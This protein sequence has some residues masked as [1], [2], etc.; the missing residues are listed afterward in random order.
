MFRMWFYRYSFPNVLALAG[1]SVFERS[2]LERSWRH[3]TDAVNPPKPRPKP[4]DPKFCRRSPDLGATLICGGTGSTLEKRN[5]FN[6]EAY[7]YYDLLV[8]SAVKV[9]FSLMCYN[10]YRSTIL[11]SP[12][13]DQLSSYRKKF[14]QIVRPLESVG[15]PDF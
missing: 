15:R 5:S 10:L 9:F 7:M 11:S 12:S 6:V 4:W 13:F 8:A 3:A 1:A 14:A 2:G